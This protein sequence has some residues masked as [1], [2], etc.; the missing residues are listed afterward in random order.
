MTAGAGSVGWRR[1]GLWWCKVRLVCGS[2]RKNNRLNDVA[3]SKAAEHKPP[4]NWTR[5]LRTLLSIAMIAMLLVVSAALV[6]FNYLRSRHAADLDA[7]AAMR[8]FCERLIDRVDVLSDNTVT[9]VG[10]AATMPNALLV[11]PPERLADKVA[12]LSQGITFQFEP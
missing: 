12:M 6:G 11:P 10:L 4:Q 8:V 9:L 2:G 1:P 5:P 7:R 3:D